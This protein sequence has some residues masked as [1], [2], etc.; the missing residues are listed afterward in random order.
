MNENLHFS[1]LVEKAIVAL[2]KRY[3]VVFCDF[4]T[5]AFVSFFKLEFS[6]CHVMKSSKYCLFVYHRSW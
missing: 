6:S 1:L 4:F 5:G 2:I 3:V